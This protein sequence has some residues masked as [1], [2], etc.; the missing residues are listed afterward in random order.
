M[1]GAGL[2]GWELRARYPF[3]DVRLLAANLPLTRT[4]LRTALLTLCVYTVL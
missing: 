4:Y 3:L 1:L 2:V